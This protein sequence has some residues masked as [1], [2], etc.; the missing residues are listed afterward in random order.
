MSHAIPKKDRKKLQSAFSDQRLTM[1]LGAGVSAGSGLPTWEKLVLAL[2][3]AT[4]SEQRLPGWRP[5][6]NY[7][8]AIADWYLT[9]RQEPLEI[10]A[11]KL[12][13]LLAERQDE[14]SDFQTALRNAL[15][16]LQ[17]D[18]L[19]QQEP[20]P[21]HHNATLMAVRDLCL[22]KTKAAYGVR[23]VITYN[24]DDLLER[25]LADENQRNV[26]P[27]FDHSPADEGHLPVFHVHGYLPFLPDPDRKD[28]G[29]IFSEEEYNQTATDPY[30]WS[31]IVQLREMSNSVG[32]MVGLSLSDRNI[33]RLLDALKQAPVRPELYA[34]MREPYKIEMSE[35]DVDQINDK[36]VSLFRE[37][38]KSGIKNRGGSDSVGF[39]HGPALKTKRRYAHD[40]RGIT[41][42]VDDIDKSMD[43]AVLKELG[44]TPIWYN[45]HSDIPKIL[46]EISD[47]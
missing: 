1:Y 47:V 26:S 36:A 15:Y 22:A 9:T 35:Q 38:R 2:Y 46:K 12:K 4:V 23:S 34:L 41:S 18:S 25:A 37:F 24:Y 39:N 10:T 21:I 19:D 42:A 27:V 13:A 5:F 6:P 30:H 8:F 3:F 14:S 17:T 29:L 16:G 40:I 32:V 7:L 44:I 45:T 43:E 11:R 20:P 28:E 33:R 31:N